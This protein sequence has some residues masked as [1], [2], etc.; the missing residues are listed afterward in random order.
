[1]GQAGSLTILIR[2][3][4]FFGILKA[5]TTLGNLAGLFQGLCGSLKYFPKRILA[6]DLSLSELQQV[7]SSHFDVLP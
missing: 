5:E 7:N 3:F 4:S 6:D 2:R 1:V